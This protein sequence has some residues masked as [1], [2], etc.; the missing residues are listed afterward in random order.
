MTG[1]RSGPLFSLFDSVVRTERWPIFAAIAAIAMLAS[2]HAFERFA[3]L[4]PCALCLRQREV[5][6][7]VLALAA[8]ALAARLIVKSHPVARAFDVLLGLAFLTGFVVA[9]Y[10][11]G[12]EWKFWPGPQTCSGT[13]GGVL[14]A[15]G[16]LLAAL[17]RPTVVVPCD[18]APWRMLGL[19]MAGWNALVSA[20]LAVL[21]FCAAAANARREALSAE[22]ADQETMAS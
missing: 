12:A 19:S 17:S 21:S 15:G 1:T 3:H 10:H 5:Y 6:W 8:A 13:P 20:G 7:G 22:R 16:D 2:A 11:A 4:P 14:A 9:V 18:E